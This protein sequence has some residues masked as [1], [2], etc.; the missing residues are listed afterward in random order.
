MSP[1]CSLCNSLSFCSDLLLF[2]SI[3]LP[4]S[5]VLDNPIFTLLTFGH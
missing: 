2:S 5:S 4:Q 3:L 1:L